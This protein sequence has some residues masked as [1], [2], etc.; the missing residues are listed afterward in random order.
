[1]DCIGMCD[2]KPVS[3]LKIEQKIYSERPEIISGDGQNDFQAQYR[4]AI[5]VLMYLM[6]GCRPDI[7]Y[8]CKKRAQFC[9]KPKIK[10]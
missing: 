1:M 8:S 3:M 4:E 2:S 5:G 7:A 10:H 6:I 9:T